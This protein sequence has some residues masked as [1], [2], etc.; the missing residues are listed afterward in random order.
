MNRTARNGLGTELEKRIEMDKLT[1]FA[2]KNFDAAFKQ[3][4]TGYC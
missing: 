3:K 4:A 2:N 1:T